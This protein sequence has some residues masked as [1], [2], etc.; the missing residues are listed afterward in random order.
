MVQSAGYAYALDSP[1]GRSNG[2]FEGRIH[3]T[4]TLVQNEGDESDCVSEE[5]ES[6]NIRVAGKIIGDAL[7]V[8]YPQHSRG[9]MQCYSRVSSDAASTACTMLPSK[10]PMRT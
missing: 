10:R 1:L 7:Q 6:T 3:E 5:E 2:S 4:Q 9:V 8:S